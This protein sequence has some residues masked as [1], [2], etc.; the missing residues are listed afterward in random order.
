MKQ[1][2]MIVMFGVVIISNQFFAA[3][4]REAA[5]S[6]EAPAEPASFVNHVQ[7]ADI[8]HIEDGL[9]NRLA[10]VNKSTGK[11][12]SVSSSI[13]PAN[14]VITLSDALALPLSHAETSTLV[15]ALQSA[16]KDD[17][18]AFNTVLSNIL[19]SRNIS[20]DENALFA[21]LKK[22][23][24][25]SLNS[26]TSSTWNQIKVLLSHGATTL[27]ISGVTLSDAAR[28]H[29][30]IKL[31]GGFLADILPGEMQSLSLQSDLQKFNTLLNKPINI[32]KIKQAEQTKIAILL[33]TTTDP[34]DIYVKISRLQTAT[35]RQPG[36]ALSYSDK[37]LINDFLKV[38]SD[39]NK[40]ALEVTVNTYSQ[41]CKIVRTFL[42]NLEPEPFTETT[43][44][45][46]FLS[47]P[48]DPLFAESGS[49]IYGDENDSLVKSNPTE[50]AR[51]LALQLGIENSITIK[52]I[53]EALAKSSFV[54]DDRN[55]KR[56]LSMIQSIEPRMK[57]AE[58][59]APRAT[60]SSATVQDIKGAFE[61]MG[62]DSSKN[63]FADAKKAYRKLVLILHP[64]KG[65]NPEKFRQLQDAY[66]MLENKFTSQE[67]VAAPEQES[68][69]SG[70]VQTPQ[71]FSGP[72][73]GYELVPAASEKVKK[74]FASQ[75]T[76]QP[77][78]TGP[79]RR[80]GIKQV[81][82]A[83]SP[84]TAGPSGFVSLG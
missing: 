37:T 84:A 46:P 28:A 3:E 76:A 58:D 83:Q 49:Y 54:A 67:V 13:K 47:Q 25:L 75:L 62:L 41:V 16:Q 70:P 1:S 69:A 18:A 71:S 4:F 65:G 21:L 66:K 79:T 38:I 27:K 64:D 2:Y 10:T 81:Q 23:E 60:Q 19:H 35:G 7:N 61:I 34:L 68:Q 77:Q 15:T 52:S 24:S 43:E 6:V 45:S 14:F 78:R 30:S 42:A 72:S 48:I 44:I 8:A 53:K 17:Y 80:K 31:S 22:S 82:S 5:H 11:I 9:G 36:T 39:S 59:A 51:R 73:S 20:F 12:T 50:F 26:W 33:G 55:V 40:P 29:P 63:T 57:A 56:W 32:E 74:S